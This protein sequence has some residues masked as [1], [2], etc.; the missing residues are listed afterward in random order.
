MNAKDL[1]QKYIDFITR[2]EMSIDTTEIVSESLLLHEA[3]ITKDLGSITEFIIEPL[4]Q[5]YSDCD[6]NDDRKDIIEITKDLLAYIK[7]E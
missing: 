4:Y 3:L 1:T 5:E 6:N 2:Y 7:G